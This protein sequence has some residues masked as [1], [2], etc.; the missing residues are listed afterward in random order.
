MNPNQKRPP[1]LF[2]E[3]TVTTPDG[4]YTRTTVRVVDCESESPNSES[5]NESASKNNCKGTC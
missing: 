1:I 5:T 2:A 3:S 4:D